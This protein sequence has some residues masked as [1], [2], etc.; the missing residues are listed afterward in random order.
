MVVLKFGGTSVQNALIIEHVLDISEKFIPGGAVLVASAMGKT[1]DKL[2]KVA[3]LASLGKKPEADT[4][5]KEIFE[6]HI[7]EARALF[8]DDS[9]RTYLSQYTQVIKILVDELKTIVIGLSLLKECTL[10]S[11]DLILSFGE[12]LSTQLL[13]LRA[14][15]R[16]YPVKLLDSREF[17]KSD[18]NFS[19]ANLLESETNAQINKHISIKKN[20]LYIVQGFI[21]STLQGITTTLGRGGSDYTA[22]IIGAAINAEEVQ[23]WTDVNGIMTSDPRI[24]EQAS[25]VKAISYQEAAELA[26]FGAR[27]LHPS[28]ILPA[29]NKNIPV[30]V[31]NTLNPDRKGTKIVSSLP[32][33]GP[34]AIAF[35]KGI[36]V[37][38]IASGRML[39]AYGFLAHLFEIFEQYKTPVD[40]IATSEVSVS[41]TIDNTNQLENIENELK[42]LG[43]VSVEKDKCIICLIGQ[44]LW[45]DSSVISRVFSNLSSIPI[46]MISLGSSD[47]NLSIVVPQERA[48]ETIK[49]LHF[50]FFEQ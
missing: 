19:S 11:N 14:S 12:R 15:Q 29:I 49:Q 17:I 6:R 1:T 7:T 26:Y 33:E 23:I 36:T 38:N 2:Q 37:I 41:V 20:I 10:R 21:A 47:T 50:E 9:N 30:Y 44:G 32:S 45:R 48:E 43:T 46:R 42:K 28:T 27:V 16:G 3:E 40:L 35:K 5:I 34:K 13:A 18:S 24:V 39:L 4:L 25:T 31:K 22:T 8:G